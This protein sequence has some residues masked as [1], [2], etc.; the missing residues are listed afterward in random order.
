NRYD[1]SLRRCLEVSS[2]VAVSRHEFL[3]ERQPGGSD[4]D[5]CGIGAT[6]LGER[7]LGFAGTSQ[8]PAHAV[9]SLL[10]ARVVINPI[11]LAV[12]QN[13]LLLD[14]PRP[15]TCRW[16]FDRRLV[17]NRRHITT[18]PAL[19]EM[20]VI[21]R[22]IEFQERA[23]IRHV[24]HQRLALPSGARVPPWLMNGSRQMLCIGDGDDATEPLSLAHVVEN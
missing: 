21:T 13:Q 10:S 2:P 7:P 12:L 18:C 20:Q 22:A 9:I 14:R 15:I 6:S 16:V 1:L 17:P 11:R 4:I 24:D 5:R 3:K 19:H 23:E 8:Y